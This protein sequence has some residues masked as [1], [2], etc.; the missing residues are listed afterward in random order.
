VLS[1]STERL[2]HVRKLP[3]YAREGVRHVCLVNPTA[4]TL[5]VLR[6]EGGRVVA[7]THG[8]DDPVRAEPFDAIELDMSALWGG[9]LPAP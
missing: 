5:E 7:A 1:P 2:D 9:R 4:R 8:G 3:V 6:L